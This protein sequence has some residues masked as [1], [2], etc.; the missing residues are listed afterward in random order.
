MKEE[1]RA[2]S[3]DRNCLAAGTAVKGTPA[4]PADERV[5]RHEVAR[6]ASLLASRLEVLALCL[7]GL[8]DLL[9]RVGVR[10]ELGRELVPAINLRGTQSD[11]CSRKGVWQ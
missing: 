1:E 8:V 2:K 7:E 5:G 11:L 10:L 6:V 9:A 4:G 3:K